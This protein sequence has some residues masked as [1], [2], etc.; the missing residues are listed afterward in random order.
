MPSVGFSLPHWMFWAALLLFPLVAWALVARTTDAAEAGR[1]NLPL[2]YI[3]WFFGGFLGLHRIYLKSLLGL[4]YLPLFFIVIWGGS[5]W[6]EARELNS[7][8]RSE[9]ESL[10]RIVDRAK[11]AAERG[12]AAAKQ[13]LDETL[14]KLE[15]ARAAEA[16]AQGLISRA[17]TVMRT[18]SLV[19]LALLLVDA[20]LMPGLVRRRRQKEPP[21][22]DLR[23]GPVL[24]RRASAKPARASRQ[25]L[26]GNRY[27]RARR[28]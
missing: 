7:K 4:I 23:S 21:P 10:N 20:V 24:S 28:R 18:A 5:Q 16:K 12:N 17:V 27:A 13:R 25:G 2:A 1:P 14:R 19:S 22:A 15:P 6:R 26:E 3:F 8:A 11:P 9:V